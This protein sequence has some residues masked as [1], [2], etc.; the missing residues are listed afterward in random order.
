MTDMPNQGARGP[1]DLPL[2]STGLG[3]GEWDFEPGD[4]FWA[5]VAKIG[6]GGDLAAQMAA[7]MDVAMSGKSAPRVWLILHEPGQPELSAVVALAFARELGARDQAALILDCDD[8]SQSLTRWAERVE[9]EGWI[10][11]ARYGTSVLT[12]GVPTP[13]AGRRSYLLG[14][15]SFAP[16]DVT[17]AE[18]SSL[19]Q[20][21]RRQADDVILV[22]P[23]DA[24]GRMWAPAAGIRLL[25]WDR[26]NRPAGAIE[27]LVAAL[28]AESG[29]LTGLVGFGLPPVVAPDAA[30]AEAPEVAAMAVPAGESV[31][32]VDPAELADE[33]GAPG[34]GPE[35]MPTAVPMVEPTVEPAVEPAG[36]PMIETES[37]A[38]AE[39][40]AAAIDKPARDADSAP[41]GWSAGARFDEPEPAVRKGTSGVFWFVATAAVVIVVILGAYW[42]KY[43]RVPPEGYFRPVEVATGQQPAVQLP[44]H[45]VA[46][47]M[48]NG[49]GGSPAGAVGAA[50]DSLDEAIAEG[51]VEPADTTAEAL[52]AD[53]QPGDEA[54]PAAG[55]VTPTSVAGTGDQAAA[56]TTPAAAAPVTAPSTEAVGQPAFSMAPYRG[57]VGEAGWALHLYSLPDSVTA[58]KEVRELGRRGFDTGIRVVETKEK[59]RWWRVYVGSFA[60]RSEARA[61]A[62]PLK[63]KLQTDW[64]N[65]TRF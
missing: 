13:F 15:G 35:G 26:T 8:L 6:S 42:Y 18:I 45:R 16:T 28:A 20:R 19:V 54:G 48:A 43:V 40:T 2:Y 53:E 31:P 46:G 25:C 56:E 24:I 57:T 65:P 21:L 52:A 4:A 59:G 30:P 62:G 37:P 60:T 11:L 41:A 49:D 9:C 5:Q 27:G 12:S 34:S 36:E 44:P 23:A 47:E 10:D 32:G 29:P 14:V 1:G 55:S 3:A 38:P 33:F 50:V 7:H 22:A 39:P 17:A 51:A 61:A 64:A 58:Q 63:E